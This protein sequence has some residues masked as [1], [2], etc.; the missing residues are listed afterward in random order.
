[1]FFVNKENLIYMFEFKVFRFV[2][3]LNFYFFKFGVCEFFFFVLFSFRVFGFVW[4]LLMF[5]VVFFK[6]RFER[7]GKTR[8]DCL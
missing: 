8:I 5:D 2:L 4:F 6:M 7:F 3:I 1:M